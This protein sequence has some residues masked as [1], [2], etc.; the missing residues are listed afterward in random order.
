MAETEKCGDQNR[1]N[2]PNH[3]SEKKR[4][5]S[6]EAADRVILRMRSQGVKNP[7]TLNSYCNEDLRWW[8]IGNRRKEGLGGGGGGGEGS[9]RQYLQAPVIDDDGFQT[10]LEPWLDT[11]TPV[12]IDTW[13]TF[14]HNRH[15][16]H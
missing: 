13:D 5:P 11:L 1:P 14:G 2:R 6:K 12:S 10:V 9:A 16:R 7:E 8:F 3:D 15:L 4:Y